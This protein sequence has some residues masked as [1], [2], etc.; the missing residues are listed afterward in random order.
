VNEFGIFAVAERDPDRRALVDPHGHESSYGELVA[1]MNAFARG[2]GA[3]GLGARG[4]GSGDTVAV[5]LPNSRELLEVYGAAVQT[6]LTFVALNW[7]LGAEELSYVLAD[8]GAS[9]LVVHEQFGEAARAAAERSG[10][11]AE[12]RFAVGAVPGFR[13]LAELRDGQSSERLESRRAGRIMF[14]TSGTTGKPKGVS[15]RFGETPADEIALITG[16]GLRASS[17]VANPT[18][19]PDTRVD[20]VSG[21][22]YHAAPIA[23]ACGALDNGALLVMMDRF[24]PE[25][26]LD[27]VERYHV[28]NAMMVPTMFHRL[29]SLS[30]DVRAR[31]D[32]SSLQVVSHAGAPCPIDVKRRMIEWW[33]PVIVEAYSSTEG[34]GTTVT[35]EEWLR[36]PGTVG[37]PSGGVT[38]KIV[39][40]EGNDCP[41]GVPGLVY[42]SQTLWRFEYHNDPGKTQANRRGELF[43]VG[44]IGY[45][46]DDGYL[47]LCD[48]QADVIVSGGV[49]VYPAEVEATLLAHPAVADAAVVG[50]PSDEWGEEVRAVVE[51]DRS[52]GAVAGPELA[53]DLIDSCRATIA[54]YKCPRAVDF[55]ESLGRDPNGKVRKQAIRDRYWEGRDR[56]I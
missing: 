55:V 40:D 41:P 31:A 26:F 21:P 27:R 5:L 30:D 38:L 16:I 36:K 32:V 17:F 39:D 54:H 37:M 46:D 29:L 9:A 22:M 42:L 34:A 52:A 7:H 24:A 8:S 48:R 44:D 35:S 20:L 19:N 25:G 47:F 6:G 18:P 11:P 56:K 43:T 33:G 14:Y 1:H 13:P 53:Q 15:K 50:V 23:A 28:T 10:I 2:L 12:A 45:L 3:R 4:L 49:N 51:V